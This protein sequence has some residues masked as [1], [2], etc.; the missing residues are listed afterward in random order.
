MKTDA[1][2]VNLKNQNQPGSGEG[3]DIQPKEAKPLARQ[4]AE[5]LVRDAFAGAVE[6]YAEVCFAIQLGALC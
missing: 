5:D 2:K 4:D 3:H 6:R 1:D